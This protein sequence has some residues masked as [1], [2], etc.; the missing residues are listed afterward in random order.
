MFLPLWHWLQSLTSRA[1]EALGSTA[2]PTVAG[3]GAQGMYQ[4]YRYVRKAAAQL[5]QPQVPCWL[6][7]KHALTSSSPVCGH[8]S[9]Q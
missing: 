5:Q 8:V 6:H 3:A 7:P 1:V 9:V 2:S 4:D